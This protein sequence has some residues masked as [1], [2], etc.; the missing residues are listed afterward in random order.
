MKCEA[1]SKNIPLANGEVVD[2]VDVQTEL[3]ADENGTK[4][5]HYTLTPAVAKYFDFIGTTANLDSR[6]DGKPSLREF[7]GVQAQT[8]EDCARLPAIAKLGTG[9]AVVTNDERLVLG[10]RGRLAVAG[11]AD[12]NEPRSLI[13]VVGEGTLPSDIGPNGRLD[14]RETALRGLEEELNLGDGVRHAARVLEL[15]DSGF[16]FDQYRWQPCFGYV[17]RIDRSWDELRTAAAI[18]RDSW[19]IERL[20]SLP[21]DIRHEGLCRLLT[22]TH[23]DLVLASNHAAAYIWM[24]LLYKHGFTVVRDQLSQR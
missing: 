10:V 2:I 14:P 13:H 5:L 6:I 15:H 17:A 4:L 21:F 20:I 23:P 7:A 9:T 12:G 18:A 16:F 11:S 19:E 22:G 8:V 3:V 1:K 24:A